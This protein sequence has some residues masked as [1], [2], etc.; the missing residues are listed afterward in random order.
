MSETATTGGAR[1]HAR[2][3]AGRS[4]PFGPTIPARAAADLPDRVAAENVVWRELVGPGGYTAR[5]VDRGTL[6][7]LTDVEGDACAQMLVFNADRPIERLNV[8]DTVKVQ[9]QAYLATNALLLSDMGR[10]LMSIVAD[11]GGAHDAL[12]GA[13]NK[14]RNAAKYGSGTVHGPFPN[15]RDRF[16]V[17]LAKFGLDRRDIHPNV[18]FFKGARVAPDGGLEFVGDASRPGAVVELRAELPLLVVLANTPHVLDPRSEYSVTPLLVT[19]WA[20]LPTDRDDPLWSSTPERER[21]F[22]NTEDL[23]L[24]EAATARA[25]PV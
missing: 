18:T 3:Q 25:E 19:A 6:V 15:A 17:A 21:A 24:E 11:T 7:R 1:D 13:S 8:A 16:A 22:L 2:A 12:C 20:D 4:A 9:W 14:E 10:V 5:V 23:L